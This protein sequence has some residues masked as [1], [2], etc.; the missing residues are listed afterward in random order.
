MTSPHIM[1]NIPYA[2]VHVWV[3][4]SPEH[5][6]DCLVW[7]LHSFCFLSHEI[8]NH[9]S[10]GHSMETGNSIPDWT[11]FHSATINDR[12]DES[13]CLK[14][15]FSFLKCDSYFL[16]LVVTNRHFFVFT[17]AFSG[18][19]LL[20]SFEEFGGWDRRWHSV[21]HLGQDGQIHKLMIFLVDGS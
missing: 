20:C 7:F 21:C 11:W 16:S 6:L 13:K 4:F 12:K 3:Q 10:Q 1:L 19:E 14:L 18:P 2:T 5:K 9:C 8:P 17:L 15:V